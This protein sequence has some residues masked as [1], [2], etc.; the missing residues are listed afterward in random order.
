[1]VGQGWACRD[2]GRGQE[3]RMETPDVREWDMVRE[4][5]DRNEGRGSAKGSANR[6]ERKRE[7]ECEYVC[8]CVSA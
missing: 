5:G 1:M 6:H 7:K 4:D 2:E 8:A 3:G